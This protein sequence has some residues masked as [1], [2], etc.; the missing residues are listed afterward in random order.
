LHICAGSTWAT[1]FV[2]SSPA[3]QAL[4]PA[5]RKLGFAHWPGIEQFNEALASAAITTGG[6]R[7][8]R[9][10]A[11]SAS[12]GAYYEERAF[13]S[14]EILHREDDWHD[15]F[16]ALVWL[17]FPRAKAT[18]NARHVA[19]LERELPGKRGRVRDAL[20]LFD[21]D[22]IV[23][24]SADRNL[25]ALI[26][27]FRWKE[28]FWARRADVGAHM[29]FMIFGHGLYTKARA[30]FL[31]M[32]G[33]AVLMLTE[34]KV[35]EMP[36]AEKLAVLDAKLEEVIGTPDV[37]RIPLD[38]S[39]VPILGIPEWTPA[40]RDETFYDNVDYF[41]PGRAQTRANK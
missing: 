23:V 32:T 28:L 15:L 40:N 17:T 39:P 30:P 4:R 22:G 36:M 5:A 25:L 20:T 24:A 21:E 2:E 13:R 37:V 19:E 11:P 31:G 35:L 10:V 29:R 38:L 1:E 16:N 9:L 6:G 41:R 18:L 8:A 3:F 14:G 33:R 12:L 26:R 7:Q 34:Q 27:E